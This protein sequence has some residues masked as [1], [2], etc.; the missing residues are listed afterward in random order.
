MEEWREI[1][2]PWRS[3]S[4]RTLP[5]V[6]SNAHYKFDARLLGR[7]AAPA[8]SPFPEGRHNIRI[9]L[10]KARAYVPS[11]NEGPQRKRKDHV[12][13]EWK[14]EWTRQAGAS[15]AR[16]GTSPRDAS[17]TNLYLEE[18]RPR[19]CARIKSRPPSFSPSPSSGHSRLFFALC[20]AFSPLGLPDRALVAAIST[21]QNGISS[22]RRVPRRHGPLARGASAGPQI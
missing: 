11:A 5:V 1:E 10:G 4:Y 15:R 9:Q 18:L 6:S 12:K 20:F 16:K 21:S 2:S 22:C 14:G 17:R 13:G 7:A 8:S 3:R 19:P